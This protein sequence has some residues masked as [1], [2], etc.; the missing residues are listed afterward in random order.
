LKAL[1]GWTELGNAYRLV[2]IHGRDLRWVPQW[3]TW[4][5]WSEDEARWQP[6]HTGEVKRRAE[7]VVRSLYIE[8]S[9]HNDPEI[10]RKAAAHARRSESANAFKAMIELAQ[11]KLAIQP[12]QLDANVLLFNVANGTVDLTTLELR[13]PRREDFNTKRS[14]AVYVDE[15]SSCVWSKFLAA[16]LPDEEVRL[17]FKRWVGYT[18]TGEMEAQALAFLYGPPAASKSTTISAL[19]VMFGDYATA[20][21]SDAFLAKNTSGGN[22]PE[23]ARLQG[24]R[25]AFMSEMPPNRRFD[26][27]LVK[28]WTGGDAVSV[29]AKYQSPF[30]LQPQA[31]LVFVGNDRPRVDYE[32]G[33]FWRRTF[34]VPFDVTVPKEE[35]DPKLSKKLAAPDVQA[36]ILR[37]ALDGLLDYREHGLNPPGAVLAAVADYQEEVDPLS[38]FIEARCVLGE[39]VSETTLKLYGSYGSFTKE[40]GFKPIVKTRFGKVL[41][42][43]GFTATKKAGKRG[44]RGIALSSSEP[45][46]VKF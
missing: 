1:L 16:A 45:S 27:A 12:H 34:L 39:N 17:F 43:R 40:S 8:T 26:S 3:R 41:A 38:D 23:L 33:A 36:E 20:A 13:D 30:E 21:S 31:K 37:W 19:R 35:R 24:V 29:C 46:D 42:A 44:W 7:E 32:D 14:P 22:S 10:R 6:D 9:S 28:S 5:V 15:P 11:H 25:V 4:I 2:A 18:L